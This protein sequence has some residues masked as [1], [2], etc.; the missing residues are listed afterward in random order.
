MY[1]L[2]IGLLEKVR[3]GKGKKG[4]KREP[5]KCVCFVHSLRYEDLGRDVNNKTNVSLAAQR[6]CSM[7]IH[8]LL[9]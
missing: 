1:E 3:L 2:L 5:N 6:S 7:K 9:R 4:L 8:P